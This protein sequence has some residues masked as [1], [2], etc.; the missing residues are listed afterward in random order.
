M[1]ARRG[2]NSSH[3]MKIPAPVSSE[4]NTPR[5][6]RFSGLTVLKAGARFHQRLQRI[7]KHAYLFASQAPPELS[8][9]KEAVDAGLADKNTFKRK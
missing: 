5:S 1:A 7:R 2:M 9:F 3:A 8:D 6:A 4:E